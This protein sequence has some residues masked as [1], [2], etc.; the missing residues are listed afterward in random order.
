MDRASQALAERVPHG[1]RN[2]YRDLADHHGVAHSTLNDRAHGQRSKEEKAQS[3][4]FL[5]PCEENAVVNFVLH[6]A[7]FGQCILEFEPY[8]KSK[9]VLPLAYLLSG[10]E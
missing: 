7:R 1:V 2:T 6:M 9:S 4:Q 5:T 3:Q 8:C 10:K